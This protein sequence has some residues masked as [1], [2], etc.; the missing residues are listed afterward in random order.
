MVDGLVF[1]KMG[2]ERGLDCNQCGMVVPDERYKVGS[3]KSR[4]GIVTK[5]CEHFVQRRTPYYI[6]YWCGDCMRKGG[7]LW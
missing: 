4:A 1:F 6:G 3:V 7:L 5:S 2:I